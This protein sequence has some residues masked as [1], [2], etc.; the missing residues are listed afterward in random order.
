MINR[1]ILDKLKWPTLEARWDQS[2]L[3]LFHNIYCE[4]MSVGQDKIPDPGSQVVNYQVIKQLPMLW[5][6]DLC[7]ILADETIEEFRYTVFDLKTQL[8]GFFSRLNIV[9]QSW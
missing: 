6:P 8:E 3:L 7:P 1:D 9:T 5:L 2:S 4:T